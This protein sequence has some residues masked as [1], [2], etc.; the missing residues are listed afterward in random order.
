MKMLQKN[1]VK[2]PKISKEFEKEYEG[3]NP[4]V[5]QILFNRGVQKKADIKKFLNPKIED[6]HDPYLMKDMDKT[7]KRILKAVENKEKII[8]YGDFD[9]DGITATVTLWEYLY[10]T[11]KAN[12]KP[13]IPHKVDEGYGLNEVSLKKLS[14]ES[15]DLIITV[16]CGIRDVEL[17]KKFQGKTFDIIV[18]DHHKIG[19]AVPKA[20]SIIHPALEGGKYPFKGISG[21]VVAWKLVEALRLSKD[22]SAET[23]LNDLVALS[24]VCDVMPLEDE[25][26]AIV[27]LGLEKIKSS[28]RAGLKGLFKVS[29]KTIEEAEV[30]HLGFIIGPRLNATGRIAHAMDAVRL[31]SSKD[32]DFV[33]QMSQKIN[34]LNIKRQVMTKELVEEAVGMVEKMEKIPNIIVITGED[35]PD[36]LLGLVAGRLLDKYNRPALVFSKKED[37]LKGSARSIPEFNIIEALE[38][39]SKHLDN[40]GG[41]TM[42]AGLTVASKKFESFSEALLKKGEKLT[43]EDLVK[44]FKV[45]MDISKSSITVEMVQELSALEPHGMGNSKPIFMISDLS[46]TDSRKIGAEGKHFKGTFTDSE[47]KSIDVISF[48]KGHIQDDLDS[49]RKVDLAGYLEINEFNGNT[50][51]QLNLVDWKYSD[52]VEER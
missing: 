15:A 10:H 11:L 44:K 46:V 12:V 30:Y 6:L 16:D 24:T 2:E 48:W 52:E 42:A 51:I 36:G 39:L 34:Q 19:D 47:G 18:T 31:L 20:F 41:H 37:V 28:E 14:D 4:I 50:T 45:D 33:N 8:V 38:E 13:Y 32:S 9:V 27:K 1:W 23:K 35:W 3:I 5:A 40:Y 21:G 29:D 25:N 17:I 43:D 49:Q 22:K 7:V 26:R